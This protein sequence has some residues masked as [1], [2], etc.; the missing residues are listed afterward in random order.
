MPGKSFQIS[1]KLK[2]AG[3][4]HKLQRKWSVVN[5]PSSVN[6][7]NN[8]AKHS[9]FTWMTKKP[10]SQNIFV[11]N[12]CHTAKKASKNL[13]TNLRFLPFVFCQSLMKLTPG[14]YRTFTQKYQIM[15]KRF[16]LVTVQHVRHSD[17]AG[18]VQRRR[19]ARAQCYKT[20]YGLN[21][22]AFVIS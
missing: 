6:F 18:G 5:T 8:S 13:L 1:I 14:L 11:Q 20:F 2:P 4:N 17:G 16:K 22:R 9:F 7:I 3:P 15:I 19:E 12:F 10:F 21:L